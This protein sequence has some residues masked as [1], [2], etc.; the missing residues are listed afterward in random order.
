MAGINA[1]RQLDTEEDDANQPDSAKKQEPNDDFDINQLT[2]RDRGRLQNG[3]VDTKQIRAELIQH[4]AAAKAELKRLATISA[5]TEEG[6]YL[7]INEYNT[8]EKRIET[9][10]S[11]EEAKD[12]VDEIQEYPALKRKEA[13]AENE[14]RELDDPK[15][16][17]HIDKI[18][19]AFKNPDVVKWVGTNQIGPFEKWCMGEVEKTPNIKTAKEVLYKLNNDRNG[20]KPRKE[21]Y[22]RTV[23]PKLKKY[24]LTLDNTPYIRKEGLSE[25][26]TALAA[27]T[28]IEKQISGMRN[29]GLYSYK[30]QKS[31]MQEMLTSDNAGKIKSLQT[32][33]NSTIRNESTQFTNQN[34][35]I[36]KSSMVTVHG[37]S[38]RSMSDRSVKA[39]LDDYKEYD[40]ATRAGTVLDWKTI[41][42]NEGKLVKELGE[43]YDNDPDGFKSALKS[44]SALPYMKKEKALKEHK[45]LREKNSKEIVHESL[46]ILNKSIVAIDNA[47]DSGYLCNRTANKFRV[48][49]HKSSNY[50]NPK[51]GEI[52]LKKQ[53]DLHDK[54]TS[55]TA[56]YDKDNRNIAAYA[57]GHKKFSDLLDKYAKDNPDIDREELKDWLND[58]EEG[59]FS[60]RK[61]T[62][63][64]LKKAATDAED[65][66]DENK[67]IETK[68]KITKAEKNEAENNS[69]ERAKLIEAL[70]AYIAEKTPESIEKGLTAIY[71]YIAFSKAK[72]SED[73]ELKSLR[74]ELESLESAIGQN[75]SEAETSTA[76]EMNDEAD[77]VIDTSPNIDYELDELDY[78]SSSAD[79][80]EESERKHGNN[81]NARERSK[82]DA[83]SQSVDDIEDDIIE[84]FYDDSEKDVILNEEATGDNVIHVDFNSKKRM[85]KEERGDLQYLAYDEE[86]RNYQSH[87]GT[88]KIEIEDNGRTLDKN[89]R[90]AAINQRKGNVINIIADKIMARRQKTNGIEKNQFS[91]IAQQAAAKRAAE[92]KVK[93]RVDSKVQKD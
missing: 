34:S 74:N 29:T 80:I 92:Q 86:V 7:D 54:L 36:F 88:S 12:L 35:S 82:K 21:F 89:S 44:F 78:V 19:N 64:D 65:E 70:K 69:P 38:V 26:T 27:I 81:T 46:N 18:A 8:F 56:I 76:Q 59:T 51:N 5:D 22:N 17:P 48:W 62:Y 42:D 37:V 90:E 68:F 57:A 31:I 14:K 50:T 85:T 52:D 20:L 3:E 13:K 91:N 58:Y 25:R 10:K 45:R 24:G 49:A 87:E 16:K 32:Q 15:L 79:L 9:V 6:S 41:I 61:T 4:K 77:S 39:F 30:A 47:K 75:D 67:K 28:D 93:D 43:I 84:S 2:P 72:I 73:P 53:Q 66:K 40:L 23:A 55:K 60:E 33:A 1:L 71:L 63:L 11:P 83:L